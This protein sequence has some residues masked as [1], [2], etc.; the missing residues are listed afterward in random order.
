MITIICCAISF[1]VGV[2]IGMLM[3]SLVKINNNDME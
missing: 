3:I 2:A 1:S